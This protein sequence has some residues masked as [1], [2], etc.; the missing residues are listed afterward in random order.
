MPQFSSKLNSIIKM[1]KSYLAL[2][3]FLL[4]CS[5]WS[6]KIKIPSII[7]VDSIEQKITIPNTNVLINNPV[8]YTFDSKLIAYQ[9][10]DLNYF[11]IS[12]LPNQGFFTSLI[13]AK[14]TL[15]DLKEDGVKF[16]IR[17]KILL[18]EYPGFINI[19]YDKDGKELI[20]LI[21]GDASF[22]VIIIGLFEKNNQNPTENSDLIL[23]SFYKK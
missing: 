23:S 14:E 17:Q 15:K 4:C 19:G 8:G 2:F 6:Q 12:E 11:Q 9:K 5:S 1:I 16:S 10:G 7:K 13:K 22:S 20:Y 18:D 3:T 21:F